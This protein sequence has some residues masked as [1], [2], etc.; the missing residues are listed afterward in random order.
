M[1]PE[2]Y[3]LLEA[4]IHK[5]VANLE[6]LE[7]ELARHNLFPRIQADSLGGF[8]LADEASLRIIGSILHDYYTAIEKIFRI[9][10]RDIDCSVPAGEQWHKE[11]LDQ[12]TLEVPGLRPALLAGK[13]ARS[14]DELR[15]FRHAFRNIYGFSLDPAKIRQLLEGLPELAGDFKKDLHLFTLRMRRILGLDSSSEV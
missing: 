8:S 2:K 3:L 14:L 9:I 6:R 5:E 7:R 10:A 4:R 11:L 15:A 1:I 13:T 12:M